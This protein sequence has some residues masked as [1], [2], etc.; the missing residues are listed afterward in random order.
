[1]YDA[2]GYP[3]YEPF[4]KDAE[5]NAWGHWVVQVSVSPWQTMPVTLVTLGLTEA[6]AK[7]Q[8][9]TTV[10]DIMRGIRS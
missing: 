1:M 2:Q 10:A 8:A 7:D 5:L 4:A 6:E 9:L 3:V